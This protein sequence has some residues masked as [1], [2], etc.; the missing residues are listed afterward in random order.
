MSRVRALRE[1]HLPP[2][3]QVP[4]YFLY[5]ERLQAP[6][7]R[8]IH[9]ETIA[10]RSKLHDWAIR[11]H[12]HRDLHQILLVRRG[13]A[14]ARLDG[15]R[16]RL[17][18]PL[19][20]IVPPGVVH[21]FAFEPDTMGLVVSFAPGLARELAAASQGLLEFLEHSA[22]LTF[23]RA[24]VQATD[25]WTL[26]DLLLREFAR[27]APG[28][29]TALRGLLGALLA[30][31]LRLRSHMTTEA[32]EDSATRELVAKFRRLVE[33]QY[34]DHT[35]VLRYAATLCTSEASLR[36]ACLA[37]TGQTPIELLHLRL[38]VEAERQLRYT[39]M[40]VT[41][42]AYYLGFEDPAYFSRFFSRRMGLS[43]RGFRARDGLENEA[44]TAR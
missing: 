12:R 27:S 10:T 29:H 42:V 6:D 39:S 22:A 17:A 33:R 21:A 43:P 13:S 18:T 35:S 28:R 4:A 5:G 16:T 23:N 34:R 40:S 8:L 2:D 30:N 32:A 25:L 36:R 3:H 44:A 31:V 19:A 26:G 38:L 20:I 14:E 1:T 9:I 41:Q 15:R 7:E 11:P 24:A 37:S